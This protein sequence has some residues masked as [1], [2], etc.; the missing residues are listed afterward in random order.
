[1]E[2]GR[3][4]EVSEVQIQQTKDQKMINPTKE[5]KKNDFWQCIIPSNDVVKDE[6]KKHSWVRE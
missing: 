1:M 5:R 4:R 2:R 6:K 3:G